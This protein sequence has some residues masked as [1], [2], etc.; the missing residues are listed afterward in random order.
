MQILVNTDNNIEGNENL[1]EDVENL[2]NRKLKHFDSDLTRI[3]VHINDENSH[4]GGERDKR[5]VLEAR[6]KHHRPV[7]VTNQDE[8]IE[9]A[10]IGASDKLKTA[11]ENTFGRMKSS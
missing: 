2:L 8:T 3:E 7:T 6:L 4:K 5:C 9:K 1:I 10:L 11:L